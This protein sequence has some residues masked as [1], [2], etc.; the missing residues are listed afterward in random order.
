MKKRLLLFVLFFILSTSSFFLMAAPAKTD[1]EVYNVKIENFANWCDVEIYGMGKSASADMVRF[2]VTGKKTQV[3]K[4]YNGQSKLENNIRIIKISND[5]NGVCKVSIEKG[6][7]VIAGPWINESLS[8]INVEDKEFTDPWN[9]KYYYFYTEPLCD[10][11]GK[12]LS[13]LQDG[14]LKI[15]KTR[16]LYAGDVVWIPSGDKFSFDSFISGTTMIA[17]WKH[18]SSPATGTLEGDFNDDCSI[19]KIA[20]SSGNFDWS[21]T[22]WNKEEEITLNIPSK[23]ANLSGSWYYANGDGIVKITAKSKTEFTAEINWIPDGQ[24]FKANLKIIGNIIMGTWFDSKGIESGSFTGQYKADE[25][26]N[27]NIEITESTGSLDWSG[28][29]W[30]KGKPNE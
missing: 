5:P 21:E 12:W 6:N 20:S 30:I 7:I 18:S 24:K 2:F 14:Y 26:E 28:Y 13:S 29:T 3:E 25:N 10:P 23:L 22:T 19:L 9:T 17:N 4:V 11:S 27:P 8:T 1:G 16:S 15:S